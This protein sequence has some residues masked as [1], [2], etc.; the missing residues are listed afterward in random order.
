[1][2]TQLF[3]E[4]ERGMALVIS[5]VFMVLLSM[6]GTTAV[7]MT[8][9]DMQ[10]GRNYRES[11]KAFYDAD[12]GVNY[13]LKTIEAG[14]SAGSFSLPPDVGATSTLSYTTPS[15]FSFSISDITKITD[16]AYSFTSTGSGPDNA[17]AVINVLF[18]MTGVFNYGIFGDLGVTLSGN[19]RTDSYNSAN[20]PYTWATHNTEGDVGTNATSVGAI[21]LSGNAKVYGDA[22]I[23]PGGDPT[24]GVKTRG[25][26]RIVAP[27]QKLAA[28]E[29]K[30]MSPYF[31]P[32]PGGGMH[33]S[34]W[35]VSGN[36]TDDPA[37][38]GTY[39]IPSISIS[40][41]GT[42]II[43]GDATFYVSGN[44]SISGNG[45]LRILAGNTV[46]IYAG[47]SVSVSGN[48]KLR[49]ETSGSNE[50]SL[51]LF[52]SG[53]VS[54]TGNGISNNSFRPERLQIYG[55][56]TCSTVNI[57]GNGNIYAAI[58]APAANIHVSGNGD[59]YGSTIGSTIKISG[60]GNVHYDEALQ[61]VGPTSGLKLVSWEHGF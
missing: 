26:A 23:G 37:Y 12:A 58:Y 55:S 6:L 32:G 42:G 33:V 3:L 5:L 28:D 8:T 48:G 61:N 44:I 56:S 53:P 15:G 46:T 43:S 54:V 11:A 20:G 17:E 45:K 50:S 19:G 14:A 52:A 41:N 22:A 21:S 34:A 9:T 25:N 35:N 29:S 47:G 7:V 1:M 30:D 38:S 40:G 18:S 16:D 60:N 24:T 51:K 31:D 27:G 36:N 13:T 10:I 39:Q 49:L 59:I 2:K 57:S 4:S